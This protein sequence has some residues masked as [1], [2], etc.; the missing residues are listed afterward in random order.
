LPSGKPGA[1]QAAQ[2]NVIQS[3][4]RDYARHGVLL[5]TLAPGLV[6]TDRNAGRRDA[7]PAAWDQYVRGLNWMGRAGKPEEMVG[8]AVFLASDA[9][10]FMT[11]ESMVLSGGY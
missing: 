7:D 1:V 5:N 4:A 2:H 9:C 11:G 6:D 10:S 3:Q 8:A